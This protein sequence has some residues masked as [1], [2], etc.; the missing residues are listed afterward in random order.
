MLDI[1]L[2]TPVSTQRSHVIAS[3]F[4]V[5]F[6]VAL[7][8][9]AAALFASGKDF[10]FCAI[11]GCLFTVPCALSAWH[12]TLWKKDEGPRSPIEWLQFF[13][14]SA[15]LSGVFVLIDVLVVHP[16]FSLI[17]TL[18]ALSMA[19]I[20]LPGAA[21]AWMIDFMSARQRIADSDV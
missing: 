15:V 9:S 7:V 3:V 14:G 1:T 10:W 11:A 6:V 5:V 16:S 4:G 2:S 8:T 18:G 17:L 19:F 21:R 12:G 20:A 13:I